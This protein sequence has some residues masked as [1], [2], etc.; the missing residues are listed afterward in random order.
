M[1][2]IAPSFLNGFSS[3]LQATR[4]YIKAWTSL[5]IKQNQ[6]YTV[7]LTGVECREKSHTF[8]MGDLL[9]PL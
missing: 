8:T 5:N 7:Q 2:T 3:F 9:L 6:S 1:T 4:T